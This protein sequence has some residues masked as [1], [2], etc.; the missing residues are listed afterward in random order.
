MFPLGWLFAD[1]TFHSPESQGSVLNAQIVEAS[2]MLIQTWSVLFDRYW[3]YTLISFFFSYNASCCDVSRQIRLALRTL[4]YSIWRRTSSSEKKL[5][6]ALQWIPPSQGLIRWILAAE[7]VKPNIFIPP[8]ST[9][10]IQ[11]DSYSVSL[12]EFQFTIKY[13]SW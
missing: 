11:P 1:T 7:S 8:Y 4:D 6:V 12:L 9:L 13:P 3:I 2:A 10:V 5:A